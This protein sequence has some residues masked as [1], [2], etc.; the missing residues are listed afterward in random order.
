MIN[1]IKNKR[2][3]N[4]T[5]LT[6]KLL[7]QTHQI[8]R[9]YPHFMY[10]NISFSTWLLISSA[11]LLL[12]LS[13]GYRSSYGL[14]VQPISADSDWGRDVIALSLAIQNLS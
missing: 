11:S 6:F 1:H 2:C 13:F 3:N 12:L 8:P 10:K 7:S 14:F 9:Q 4:D 5:S